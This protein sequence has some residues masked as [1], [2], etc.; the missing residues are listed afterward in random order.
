MCQ[1]AKCQVLSAGMYALCTVQ[2]AS[3]QQRASHTNPLSVSFLHTNQHSPF[4]SCTTHRHLSFP[5]FFPRTLFY[6][7]LLYPTG[8]CLVLF[9]SCLC[10]ADAWTIGDYWGRSKN[11]TAEDVDP[12]IEVRGDHMKPLPI[13]QGD[14]SGVDRH[15]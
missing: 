13:G 1:I 5:V 15:R 9:A 2:P 12:S 8:Y 6:F 3:Q 4:A 7:S 11:K 14:S 10:C